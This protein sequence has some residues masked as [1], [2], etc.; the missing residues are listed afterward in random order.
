LSLTPKEVELFNEDVEC[1][2]GLIHEY[3]NDEVLAAVAI[4][5]Q[6]YLRLY[7]IAYSPQ[8]I[9][10]IREIRKVVNLLGGELDTYAPGTGRPPA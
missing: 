3:G 7:G 10:R 1:V 9:E 8:T 4:T 6:L 5:K 2:L